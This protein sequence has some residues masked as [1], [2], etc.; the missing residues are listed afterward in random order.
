MVTVAAVVATALLVALAALQVAL[1][2][3]A[4][5]GRLAWGG[6]HRVLP[7]RLRVGSAV[8]VLLY[9]LFAWLVWRAAGIAARPGEEPGGVAIWALTVYFAVGVVANAASRS[10]PERAVMTPVAAVLAACC[11]VVALG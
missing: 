2:A 8:S 10:R 4:P 1:A 7:T 11:L 6:H 3:G 9:A 5:L